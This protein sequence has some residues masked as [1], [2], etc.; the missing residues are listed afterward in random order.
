M[1]RITFD[2]SK[3]RG[4]IVEKCGTIKRF[5]N[6]MGV[7][8]AAVGMKLNNK[9]YFSQTDIVRAVTV[10][11]ISPDAVSQYFFTQKL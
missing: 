4:R 5:A 3:L 10:L 11:D 9:H 6:A 7:T 8:S 1:D 2:Y